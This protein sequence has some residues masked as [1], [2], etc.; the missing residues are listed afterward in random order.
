MNKRH[1]ETFY[2]RR[3]IQIANKHMRD[4]QHQQSLEKSRMAKIKTNDNTKC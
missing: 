2:G 3:Y 4:V 1:E